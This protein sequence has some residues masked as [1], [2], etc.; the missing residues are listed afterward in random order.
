MIHPPVSPSFR[1]S[2]SQRRI[3]LNQPVVLLLYVMAALATACAELLAQSVPMDRGT[4]VAEVLSPTA[5]FNRRPPGESRFEVVEH[6]AKLRTGELLVALPGAQFRTISGDVALTCRADFEGKSPLPILETAIILHE[7]GEADLSLTLQRGRIDLVNQKSSGATTIKIRFRDRQWKVVLDRI[8]SRVA[9]ETI[10]RWAPGTPLYRADPPKDH[11]PITSVVLL[12]LAGTADVSDGRITL[13]LSAPP[14]PAMVSWTSSDETPL[15]AQKLEEI[16]DWAKESFLPPLSAQTTA[17]AV[18][19]FRQLRADRP[20][21]AVS[22]F[23]QSP[24]ATERR[25]GLIAAGAFDDLDR[26]VDAVQAAND[27]PTWDFA[28]SVLR[29]WLGRDVG[30]DQSLYQYFRDRR[31]TPAEAETAITLLHGFTAQE[32]Q[33]PETFDVLIEYLLHERPLIR[34]L[35]AWHLRRLA[36]AGKNIPFLPN[37][38]P[39]QMQQGYNAWRKLIPVG[40]LP[41]PIQSE[42]KSTIAG[43]NDP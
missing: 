32:Q 8:G 7:P 33:Q 21:I 41:P 39:E 9:V 4:A 30:Q 42:P 1:I 15:N 26:V 17:A 11:A 36:P 6:K 35:A 38:T 34:N 18:E 13:A 16:P 27:L 3:S 43:D 40:K 31:F 20:E 28:V 37:A 22:R 12:V 14:G 19:K 24:D 23:V 10:A 2:D 5:S 29:H 25:I